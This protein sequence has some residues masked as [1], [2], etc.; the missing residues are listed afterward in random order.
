MR[1]TLNPIIAVM[2]GHLI[3]HVPIFLIL[4]VYFFSMVLFFPDRLV[5]WIVFLLIFVAIVY[6]WSSFSLPRWYRWAIKHGS[7]EERLRKLA[8][9][10]GL[11]WRS[12][13]A[14]RKT[15][16]NIEDHVP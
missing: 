2:L 7:P 5:F 11:A 16:A 9:S 4:G 6:L 12:S 3:V 15:Q 10:T 14:F 8:F 1:H 13:P